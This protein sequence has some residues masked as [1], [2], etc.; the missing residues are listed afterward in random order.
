MTAPPMAR[1][2][3]TVFLLKEWADARRDEARQKKVRR[4]KRGQLKA[5]K[6]SW[7]VGA[8]HYGPIYTLGTPNL[9]WT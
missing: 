5:P 9:L 4:K 6:V 7:D 8:C 3:G 2:D 1:H